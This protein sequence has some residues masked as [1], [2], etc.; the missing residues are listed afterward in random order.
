MNKYLI[1]LLTFTYNL[2]FSA[3][4][5]SSGGTAVTSGGAG[6]AW[7]NP[8]NAV[9]SDN[10][11]ATANLSSFSTTETIILTNL[12]FSI[13]SGEVIEAIEVNIEKSRSRLFSFP[14]D[15]EV[16][17]TLNGSASANNL[18][19]G[20]WPIFESITTYSA[21]SN[22]WGTTYTAE[23]INNSTFGVRVSAQ[24][25]FS[26]GTD[27][28]IDNITVTVTTTPSLL[29]VELTRFS[30]TKKEDAIAL[31]WTTGSEINNDYFEIQKSTNGIDFETIEIVAGQGSTVNQTDYTFVDFSVS[32]GAN[33]YRLMQVDYDGTTTYSSVQ[34]IQINNPIPIAFKVHPNPATNYVT[35]SNMPEETVNGV[36]IFNSFGQLV[37]EESVNN[38]TVSINISN[39]KAGS[40]IVAIYANNSTITERL[41]IQ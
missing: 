20:T 8:Q 29:P 33:Y 24:L 27:V 26:F 34:T 32:N 19:A 21:G 22:S 37:I 5:T 28:R 11:R 4:Y 18:A 13:P 25:G 14:S 39:L 16:R 30:A 3:T 40:Y 9:G 17:L 15:A 36:R 41:V 31:N 35:I 23:D 2:S 10:N 6:T 38:T 1:I 7:S 12:G